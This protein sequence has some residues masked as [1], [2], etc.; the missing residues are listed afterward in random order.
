MTTVNISIPTPLQPEKNPNRRFSQWRR[1]EIYTGPN[2]T[3]AYV[4]NQFDL[5]WDRVR[6]MY[7]VASVDY[8]TGL[9]I[10]TPIN[11]CATGIGAT[12]DDALLSI[13]PGAADHR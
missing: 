4:P 10:L 6:G 13:G 8:T 7:E 11:L 12:E 9:S 3:G 1:D 2:G 5:V